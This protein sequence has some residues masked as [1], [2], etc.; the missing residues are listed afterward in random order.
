MKNP[1]SVRGVLY[2][3]TGE[4]CCSEAVISAQRCRL[5]NPDLPITIHT[6]L[7]DYP[8]VGAS[9]DSVIVFS[10]PKYSHRDKVSGLTK[11]PYEQTLFLDTDACLIRPASDLFEILQC[12]DLAASHAPVRHP[13]GWSDVYVPSEFPEL[14]TGVLVM[15]RSTVINHLISSWLVLYDELFASYGQSW[16]QASFRSVLW[17]YLKSHQ[18]RFLHLPPEANLRTTKPWFAGRGLAVDVVHG[19]FSSDEFDPFVEFLNADVDCFRTWDQWLRLHPKTS[20]RP[21]FDR[22]FG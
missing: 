1:E 8:G 13:P 9:F 12:S 17:F 18:L 16:D 6:D 14:N 10:C 21:R 19:R 2:I 22:T 4:R 15:R 3:A 11:L 20:I 5:T 7:P